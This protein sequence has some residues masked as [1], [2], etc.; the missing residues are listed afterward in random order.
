M[1]QRIVRLGCRIALRHT[2]AAKA[3]RQNYHLPWGY[4][5]SRH[6]RIPF[7]C[8]ITVSIL[9]ELKLTCNES[10]TMNSAQQ[11]LY[12]LVIRCFVNPHANPV[13]L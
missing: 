10:R 1:G 5:Y 3:N 2:N 11:K 8:R 7:A 6:D 13:F 4:C 9:S 12:C